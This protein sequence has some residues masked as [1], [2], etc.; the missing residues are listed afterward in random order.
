MI[1]PNDVRQIR[2]AY[3]GVMPVDGLPDP[4]SHSDLANHYNVDRTTISAICSGHT[5][6]SVNPPRCNRKPNKGGRKS[7]P[8]PSLRKLTPE[9]EQELR[10]RKATGVAS[11]ELAKKYQIGRSTVYTIVS[12]EE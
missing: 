9:L 8:Q 4:P 3:D 2:L 1:K 12:R 11:K 5:W 7:G 6:A 10:Q